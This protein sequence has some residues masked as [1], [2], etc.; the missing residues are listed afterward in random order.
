VTVKMA[1]QGQLSIMDITG[2]TI[3]KFQKSAGISKISVSELEK[4]IYILKA[5]YADR[6]GLKKL[7]VH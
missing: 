7:I 4:G 1:Q 5:T 6:T 3:R 2:K